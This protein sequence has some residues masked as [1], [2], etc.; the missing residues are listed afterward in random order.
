MESRLV[1]FL[2]FIAL[3]IGALSLSGYK[4][5]LNS[6]RQMT[7]ASLSKDQSVKVV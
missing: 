5:Y 3:T 2:F 6:E 1:L 7:Y 4:K